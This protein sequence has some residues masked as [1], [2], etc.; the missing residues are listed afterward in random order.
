MN[1]LTQVFTMS[2]K[3]AISTLLPIAAFASSV[4]SQVDI[5]KHVLIRSNGSQCFAIACNGAQTIIRTIPLGLVSEEFQVC[6][7]GAKLAAIL[8]SLKDSQ[9]ENMTISWTDAVATVKVG[10]SK[11][12]AQVVDASGFPE[13]QKLGDEHSSIIIPSGLLLSSLKSVIHSCASNDARH[14]LNGCHFHFNESGF[15]VTGADGH[16]ISRVCKA[17]VSNTQV[18]SSGILPK[19]LVDLLSSVLDKVGDVRIRLSPVMIELTMQG[20]QIRSVLID[21]KFPDT[22]PFF[23]GSEQPLFSA[24]KQ[25]VTNALNRLKA[26][27]YEKLPA[28]S[29]EAEN[30]DVKLTT[31]DEQKKESGLDF[32]SAKVVDPN[33]KI[34]MNIS[35]LSDALMQIS[36]NDTVHFSVVTA[37]S[38]K[39]T[40]ENNAD[41]C[42]IIA[43][44]RR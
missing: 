41:F 31:L 20:C 37:N 6:I 22:T 12:T 19:R 35:Y 24:T 44:L 27:I 16:R 32:V 28:V 23:A 1:Q 3:D 17:I 8:S 42:A 36:D 2:V 5:Y 29:I 39:I 30:Q 33:L 38:I 15:T 4:R 7:D 14:F 10:R 43:Q 25:S 40:S 18:S 34:S 26:T 9:S 11:L 21:G 13:P